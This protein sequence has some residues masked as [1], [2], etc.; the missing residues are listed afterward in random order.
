MIEEQTIR[1]FRKRLNHKFYGLTE[2]AVFGKGG[3]V[4]TGFFDNEDDFVDACQAYN[5]QCNVYAGRNPRPV[6]ICSSRNYMNNIQKKRAK[7]K[8]IRYLTAI[9]LDIDPV[10]KK[11]MASTDKQHQQAIRFALMLQCFLGGDVDDSGN[12][13]YLWIPFITPIEIFTENFKI[14]KKKCEIWNVLLR[15][16]F[17]P[18]EL[19][20]KIDGCFDFSRLK[21]VIGT[22]NH[23][24]QRF[25]R[26]IKSSIPDDRIRD[27]ILSIEVDDYRFQK[28]KRIPFPPLIPPILPEKF[29]LLLG[30]SFLTKELWN[31]PD[32]LNDT[33]RHDWLL[34]MRCIEAGITEPEELAAILMKNPY[35]KFQRDRR[36]DYLRTTVTKLLD[37][38]KPD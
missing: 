18:E 21:R 25:S 15:K 28:L 3:I 12:G 23:K 32:P 29:K 33:S 27:E 22:F 24:A 8:D 13:S 16:K 2:L 26:F 9:S 36:E 35:G 20:L 14:I 17:K 11:G 1:T 19:G 4:A 31:N 5:E 38:Q 10:R 30:W 34:G 7:D 37:G 6:D